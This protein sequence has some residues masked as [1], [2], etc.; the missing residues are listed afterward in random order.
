MVCA[1]PA[2]AEWAHHERVTVLV[3]NGGRLT[4]YDA[5]KAGV[6]DDLTLLD[7]GYDV[8]QLPVKVG[9]LEGFTE[10]RR[11]Y[12]GDVARSR[13]G[14]KHC[15]K[16]RLTVSTTAHQNHEMM[17]ITVGHQGITHHLKQSQRLLLCVLIAFKNLGQELLEPWRCCVL[18]EL[19]RHLSG[20]VMLPVM[21]LKLP[22]PPREH[23][24]P[25]GAV[26]T[27][28]RALVERQL[29]PVDFCSEQVGHAI[30]VGFTYTIIIFTQVRLNPLLNGTVFLFA[31]YPYAFPAP[32]E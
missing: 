23:Q 15:Q 28:S 8:H 32:D 26:N 5:F 16:D 3:F 14:L 17:I 18:V 7:L 31:P 2:S 4:G 20:A 21:R 24:L 11:L 22:D 19:Y 30:H 29:W 13:Q 12:P 1:E 10:I 6:V 27:F 25:I 9:T